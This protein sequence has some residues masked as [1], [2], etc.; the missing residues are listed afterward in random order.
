[1]KAFV[2]S[3]AGG[4]EKL[5]LKDVAI[6]KVKPEWVL[7]KVKAFGLNRSEVFTRLGQSPSVRFPRILGIECVGEVAESL[8][9]KFQQGEKVA[10]MMGGMGREFDGSYA[11]FV[12]VPEKILFPIKTPLDWKNLAALPEM[13]QTTH[14]S[15]Y[16]S[17]EIKP[18]QT[19]LIRGGTS[20]IGLCALE[21]AKNGGLN[22][23]STT[24]SEAKIDFLRKAGA[25]D[26]VVD[27]GVIH[28]EI[29]KKYPKGVDR[30][31][32]LVGT[33]ALLDSLKTVKRGGILCMTGGLGGGWELKNFSPMGDIPTAVKLT[34]YMGEA[35]DITPKILQEYI[36]L[37]ERGEMKVGAAQTFPFT[38][39]P[40]AHR[41]MDSNQSNGKIVVVI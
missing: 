14:G 33:T 40:H 30:V 16:Q 7:I 2:I 11:E 21:M 1:M 19:L 9:P 28:K 18:G 5:V 3:E 38:E 26:L 39:L 25:S 27:K 22:V 24:R 17:L 4:P 35:A 10:A 23:I 6:P 12:L 41:L 13:I 36:D 37:V 31:L 8:N 20:S 32:E 34:C 15:L 29:L